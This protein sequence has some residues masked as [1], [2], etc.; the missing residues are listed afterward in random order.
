MQRGFALPLL[1]MTVLLVSVIALSYF[2]L[3]P[4]SSTE[5]QT[6]AQEVT[7]PMQSALPA[8]ASTY[9]PVTASQ[10]I[11]DDIL[12]ASLTIPQGYKLVR[13]TEEE[14]FKRANGQ[15]SKNFNYYVQ[16]PPAEFAESFYILPNEE[17]NLDKSVLAFWVFQ[18]PNNLTPIDFYKRYWYY[19]F[20]WGDYTQARNKIAP[21][22][23]IQIGGKDGMYGIVDY[24]SGKPKFIYLQLADKNL[25][26]QTQLPSENNPA[27]EQVLQSLKFE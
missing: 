11:T 17:N 18:N 16:Y 20:V 6:H 4:T 12:K 21:E 27:G 24:R 10:T 22:Q 19:P 15:I 13:E 26:V 7:V 3:K 8:S 5:L 23:L 25:M 1:L 14:Y 2:Y 9:A